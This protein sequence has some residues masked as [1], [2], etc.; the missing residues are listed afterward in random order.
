[1]HFKRPDDMPLAGRVMRE[2]KGQYVVIISF[3]K[4]KRHYSDETVFAANIKAVKAHVAKMYPTI[5]WRKR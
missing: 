3:A 5:Q 4:S 1:M 2:K